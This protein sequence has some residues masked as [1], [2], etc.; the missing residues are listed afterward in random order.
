MVGK[1]ELDSTFPII[2]TVCR[3]SPK[4]PR[5]EDSCLHMPAMWRRPTGDRVADRSQTVADHM[6]TRIKKFFSMTCCKA[7]TQPRISSK[8]VKFADRLMVA[9]S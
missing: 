5:A 3:R 6:E 2:Q 1:V 4:T 9:H 8:N 7:D